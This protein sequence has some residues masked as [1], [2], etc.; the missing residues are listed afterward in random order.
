MSTAAVSTATQASLYNQVQQYFHT[1]QSDL[2]QLGKDLNT[3]DTTDAATEYQDIVQ[4]GQS[5]PF[6]SGNAF[7]RTDR[8]SDF[9]AIGTALQSGN[10]AGAQQAFSN[11]KATF[12]PAATVQNPVSQGPAPVVPPILPSLGQSSTSQSGSTGSNTGPEI[13]LN[14]GAS[15]SSTPEQ[16]TI[17]I[18]N[19]ASGGE[20]VSIDIG[21]EGSTSQQVTTLNLPAN[22]NEQIVLNLLAASQA[23]SSSS[24]TANSSAST[25]S[26]LSVTA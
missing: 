11:L 10:L 2:Q 19:P 22:S 7:S 16:I 21:S 25:A 17:N 24:S 23:S 8:E 15:S 6:A 3:G 18:S 14:I 20:Q 4:L 5:G 9:T 1:R 12:A 26:G 13:V